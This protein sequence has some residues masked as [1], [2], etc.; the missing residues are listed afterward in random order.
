MRIVALMP[1]KAI[2][3]RVPGKNL[4]EFNGAPLYSIMLDVL[5]KSKYIDDVVINTDCRKLKDSILN[6]YPSRLI[7]ENTYVI[8]YRWI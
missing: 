5:L 3:E 4:K 1:M 7:L 6:R 2:S 8:Y